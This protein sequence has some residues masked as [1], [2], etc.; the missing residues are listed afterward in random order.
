MARLAPLSSV[1]N[2]T[3]VLGTVKDKNVAIHIIVDAAK[4]IGI[5]FDP[6]NDKPML[7]SL[8]KGAVIAENGQSV[9]FHGNGHIQK[10]VTRSRNG[11]RT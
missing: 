9:R 1:N 2:C 11:N 10:I 8:W 4:S 5:I 3:E 7:L 6:D